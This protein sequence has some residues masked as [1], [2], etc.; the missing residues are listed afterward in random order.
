[1]RSC[2]VARNL[3]RLAS[4]LALATS[5]TAFGGEQPN[6]SFNDRY[7]YLPPKILA[8]VN[9]GN[10]PRSVKVSEKFN[11]IYTVSPLDGNIAIINGK[12]NKPDGT[13]F[14][15]TDA[16]W[17]VVDDRHDKMYIA[18]AG[19]ATV[20][21]IDLRTNKTVGAPITVGRPHLPLGCNNITIPC[22][23]QGSS[24][25]HIALN[26]KTGKLYV[27]N[28]GDQ[29]I[30][31]VD[32]KTGAVDGSPIPLGTEAYF[33]AVSEKTGKIYA[34]TG[35]DATLLVI[36]EKTRRITKTVPVGIPASPDDCYESG[37]CKVWGSYS[38]YLVLN[39]E[40]DRIYVGNFIDAS[41]VVL[42]AKTEKVIGSP[43]KGVGDA[44]ALDKKSNTL[45][46]VNYSTDLLFT[47]DGD[48]NQVVGSPILA[49]VPA[50]PAGCDGF[51]IPC[52][53]YGSGA[54]DIAFNDETNR[55]YILR[56][57]DNDLVVLA[58]ANRRESERH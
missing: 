52:T 51:V 25:Y 32:T 33:I 17:S 22:T 35:L 8:N 10:F 23:D 57:N 30:V 24:P 34:V 36:D 43:I 48:T 3:L 4:A 12:T 31:V 7:G 14:S 2:K 5:G 13:V 26:T 55:F 15:G 37:D 44:I 11:K 38:D 42:D 28:L 29:T 19:D 9:A 1:M 50:T 54:T 53:D 56:Q 21:A 16:N 49:G 46:V 6:Y 18:N 41:V 58:A 40:R 47:V 39:D 20:Q 45:Y 27:G